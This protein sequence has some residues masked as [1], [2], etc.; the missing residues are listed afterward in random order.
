MSQK[1]PVE[2][3]QQWRTQIRTQRAILHAALSASSAPYSLGERFSQQTLNALTTLCPNWT[4][5]KPRIALYESCGSEAPTNVL[6]QNLITLNC[7]LYLPDWDK[8]HP[9]LPP[10]WFNVKHKQ[11]VPPDELAQCQIIILPALALGADGVRLGQGGGWY[12]RALA[13]FPQ[14]ALKIG[15][16]YQQFF[17]PAGILPHEPHDQ[18]IQVVVTEQNWVKVTEITSP[19]Y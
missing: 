9:N 4:D 2:E 3:K 15:L 14:T 1:T 5:L 12:D 8:Q 19:D 17:Y 7:S 11:P 13:A 10:A 6:H 16:T 18:M